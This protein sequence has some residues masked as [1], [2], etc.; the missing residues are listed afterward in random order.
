M[1]TEIWKLK[2]LG[3]DDDDGKFA[4]GGNIIDA[5]PGLETDILEADCALSIGA[6]IHDA[7]R[8]CYGSVENASASIVRDGLRIYSF[9]CAGVAVIVAAER[10]S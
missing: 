4:I 8:N 10:I 6:Q 2:F 5:I 7:F 3:V 1:K 9:T